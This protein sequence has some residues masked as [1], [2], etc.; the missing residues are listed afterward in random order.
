MLSRSKTDKAKGIRIKD[1][2]T[3][4]PSRKPKLI[5]EMKPGAGKMAQWV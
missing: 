4:C 5:K 1:M 3:D 2:T